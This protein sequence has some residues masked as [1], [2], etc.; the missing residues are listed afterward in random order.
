MD[1]NPLAKVISNSKMP[2]DE[3]AIFLDLAK[4]FYED[5]ETNLLLTSID[6][7]KKYKR[8]NLSEWSI[9]LDIPGV[10]KVI[11]KFIK[12]QIN[13]RNNAMLATGDGTSGVVQVRKLLDS[14][15][16]DDMS[17]FVVLRLPD[18]EDKQYDY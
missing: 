8:T 13:S 1:N 4:K 11:N 9:F 18:R 6:L 2:E 15:D 3:K 16:T 12:E 5:F 10:K 17:N 14:N 7:A